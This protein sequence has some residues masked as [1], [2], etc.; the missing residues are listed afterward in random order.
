MLGVS[1]IVNLLLTLYYFR[2][3]TTHEKVISHSSLESP[4]FIPLIFHHN[5]KTKLL[6]PVWQNSHIEEFHFSGGLLTAHPMQQ[7]M[8]TSNGPGTQLRETL[9]LLKSTTDGQRIKTYQ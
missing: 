8:R 3:Q 2:P 5:K 9:G 6:Q 1:L 7:M 4:A